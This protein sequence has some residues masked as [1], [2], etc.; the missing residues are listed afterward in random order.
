MN[1]QEEMIAGKITAAAQKLAQTVEGSIYPFQMLEALAE[2]GNAFE[3][4]LEIMHSAHP[5][6][7]Q[8]I[9]HIKNTE[10]LHRKLMLEM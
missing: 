5:L 1:Y 9:T 7:E 3:D 8:V 10:R 6:R 2:L 4:A